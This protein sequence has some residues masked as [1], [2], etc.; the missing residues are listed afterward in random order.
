[1]PQ[2]LYDHHVSSPSRTPFSRLPKPPTHQPV[3]PLLDP[4]QNTPHLLP[5]AR[6]FLFLLQLQR[7][8]LMKRKDD[9][10][11]DCGKDRDR[12]RFVNG[13]WLGKT[14]ARSAI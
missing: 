2:I 8:G 5:Q 9:E 13:R 6:R 10:G 11:F 1:M 3:D 4:P 7:D 14:K 12:L